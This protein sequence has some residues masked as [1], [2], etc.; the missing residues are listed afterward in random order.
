MLFVCTFS[1]VKLQW[2]IEYKDNRD[3]IEIRDNGKTLKKDAA[4]NNVPI[5]LLNDCSENIKRTYKIIMAKEMKRQRFSIG[6]CNENNNQEKITFNNATGTIYENNT[7][8]KRISDKMKKGDC[9]II[10]DKLIKKHENVVNIYQM[11][12][13]INDNEVFSTY[14][15]AKQRRQLLI[16][17]HDAFKVEVEVISKI[18]T[19]V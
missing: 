3:N 5:K 19:K 14:Y 11:T 18:N 8:I 7:M 10:K 2:K 16:S 6:V 15:L 13:S 17:L 9:F 4:Y 1:E 12:M